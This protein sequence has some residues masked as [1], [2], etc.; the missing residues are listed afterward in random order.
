MTGH[1]FHPGHEALHGITVVLESTGGATYI[2]RY[3]REDESGVHLLNVSLHTAGVDDPSPEAFVRRSAR[4]G[5]RADQKH[6]V[7]PTAEVLR[8]RRLADFELSQ[9]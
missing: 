3:D 6:L 9:G 1:I 7:I 4:F 2:G 8:M 5:V